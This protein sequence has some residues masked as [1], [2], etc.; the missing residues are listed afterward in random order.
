M[1]FNSDASAYAV[2][3]NS[4]AITLPGPF[5]IEMWAQST[6]FVRNSALIEQV[7]QGD[8]GAF[9]IGFGGGDSLVISLRLDNG[10][11]NISAGVIPD[12][13]NWQHYAVTFMPNDSIRVYINGILKIAVKTTATKLIAFT[14][15]VLIGHSGITGATF[16]GNI[17]EVRIWSLQRSVNDI[18]SSW[19]QTLSGTEGGLKAYY[20]FDD[21]PANKTIHDFSFKGSDGILIS[22]ATLTA[23]TSPIVGA[24]SAYMLASREKSFTFPDLICDSQAV[25]TI[26]MYNRGAQQV[27]ID[28]AAFLY[29]KIFSP[30]TTVF[31]LPP[32]S[33]KNVDIRITANVK[34]PGLYRDTLVITTSTICGGNIRIPVELRYDRIGIAF[35]DPVFQLRVNQRDLLPCDLPLQSHTYLKN[36]GTK[37][38]TLTSLDFSSPAGITITSPVLPCVII[39]GAEQEIKFTVTSSTPG[40][41]NT[42]LRAR[43]AECSQ[44][45]TMT[46]LGKRIVAAY[47]MPSHITFPSIHLPPASIT[48]DTVILLKN[49]GSSVL[50]MNPPL[51]LEG[52]LGYQ[53]LNPKSGIAVIKPDSS[54]AIRIRFTTT[55]CGLFETNLH[56]QD[57]LNCGIDTIVPISITVLGPDVSADN[58]FYD[59]GASCSAHDSVIT[60][61]NRSGRVVTLGKPNFSI[62]SIFSLHGGSLPIQLNPGDSAHIALRFLPKI[63]GS[64]NVAVHLPLSPCGEA[65]LQLHGLL[66]VGD[67]SI[68]D[69]VLDFGNGCD[70]FAQAKSIRITNHVGKDITI[71]QFQLSGSQNFSVVFPA[72]PFTLPDNSSQN[73]IIQF[74]PR[75]LGILEQSFVTL[76][77]NG[78]YVTRFEVR[79]VREH[80]KVNWSHPYVEFGTVCPG[81]TAIQDIDL[82]NQGYGDVSIAIDTMLK[83][84]PLFSI[85]SR[86]GEPIPHGSLIQLTA[87]FTPKDTGEFWALRE[88]V[89]GPCNDTT[90]IALHGIGGPPAEITLSDTV[91]DFGI[92]K[93]G[94]SDSLC[95]RLSN[96]S[97][98]GIPI[99]TNAISEPSSPFRLSDVSRASL[100]DTSSSAHAVQLCFEFAPTKIG[101]F[102]YADTITSGDHRRIVTLRGIAGFDSLVI[103]PH[104]LDFGDVLINST[105]ALPL[106][107]SN[108]GTYP[109]L[110]RTIIQ[111]SPDFVKIV[112]T[113]TINGLALV[114][115]SIRFAP[116]KLGLDTS[117]IIFRWGSHQDTIILS[118][119]GIQPGLQFPTSLLDF[120]KVRV[121]HDSSISVEV[122]NT[123]PTDITIT[124]ILLGGKFRSPSGSAIIFHSQ[125]RTYTITYSPDAEE[126]DTSTVYFFTVNNGIASLPIRGEGIEAHLKTNPSS[127]D[128]GAVGLGKT[129]SANLEIINSGGYP[130]A[131]TQVSVNKPEFSISTSGVF[132]VPPFDSIPAK[133][134]FSPSR[135]IASIDSITISA[136]APEKNALIPISGIGSFDPL[137]VPQVDYAIP[138]VQARVGDLVSLPI[139]ISGADL[140]LFNLDSFV[141][142][143]QYDPT[144]VFFHDT[145]ETRGTL[146]DGFKLAFS[147]LAHDSVIR[148][149]GKGNHI[150]PTAGRF[151]I[152][153]AEAL[154][155]PE[156]STRI[157]IRSSDPQNSASILSSSGEFVVTDCGNYRTAIAFKGNYG[158]TRIT[159]NPLS[160]NGVIEYE[161]GLTAMVHLD[162]FDKLGRNVKSIVSTPQSRGKHVAR[163]TIDDIPTGQYFYRLRSLEYSTT[164]SII[165]EK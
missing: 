95:L 68:S 75:T 126:F 62:D 84:R 37:S 11:K 52:G 61:V 34:T 141:V 6:A 110:L 111:P 77:D 25:A 64:Y 163:F 161:I 58:N 149:S 57:Q 3:P 105:K 20:S 70:T 36:T 83:G 157:F 136:D 19:N 139:S 114:V 82:S 133:V 113:Q 153:Y 21:D 138:S 164:G 123:L 106:F 55:E 85:V 101:S 46:F 117:T 43:F 78:C 59:F 38:V 96:A 102:A 107:I 140:P 143:I 86:K 132:E 15:S 160:S 60:F 80:A 147:R 142:E 145:I 14:D 89:V 119:R 137:G 22:S 1:L 56:F 120:G 44:I 93:V 92:I 10:I 152:L 74:S 100:P 32:D 151:F 88:I 148:V 94:S 112:D 109:A 40:P 73:L 24:T 42:V 134:S 48:L 156:D 124:K 33:T 103:K 135:A 146:S 23:S 30:T 69:S 51:G 79:G 17:D 155:G 125:S 98:V 12:I 41:I 9:R 49:T 50:T 7:I 35:D 29:G 65:T 154:L 115:D 54:L 16:T 2:I 104:R 159:P 122:T 66:G 71:S 13:Q 127:I 144:V 53:L 158:V 26:H 47:S 45:S 129:M 67:I 99:S 128:F 81:T 121:S 39:P 130:L 162:L 87:G 76:F 116:K 28:P 131:L 97:C 90:V 31:V 18:L 5:T 72:L 27:H 63:P 150:I 108:K 91:L 4:K 118:A 8:T 165:I